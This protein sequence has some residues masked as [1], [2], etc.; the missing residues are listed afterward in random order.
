MTR[1]LALIG[2]VSM[3]LSCSS[4]GTGE[5]HVLTELAAGI[6]LEIEALELDDSLRLAKAE[7][8]TRIGKL[9]VDA[10]CEFIPEDV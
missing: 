7:R 6:A 2:V 3:C 9:I 8:Y 10:G 4:F 5:C 1:L